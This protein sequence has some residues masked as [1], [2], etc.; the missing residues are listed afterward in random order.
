MLLFGVLIPCVSAKNDP[1]PKSPGRSGSG[2]GTKEVEYDR[3]ETEGQVCVRV[4]RGMGL[5]GGR[6]RI[7]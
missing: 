7:C 1:T 6:V 2:N 4:E 3:A 5:R